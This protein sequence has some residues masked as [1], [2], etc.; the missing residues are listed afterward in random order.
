[1]CQPRIIGGLGLRDVK[2]MNLSLLAKWIRKLL[3]CEIHFEKKFLSQSM[4]IWWEG[5]LRGVWMS[6]R[7]LHRGGGRI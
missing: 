6:G 5:C 7:G 4:V 2:V 3:P 1:M